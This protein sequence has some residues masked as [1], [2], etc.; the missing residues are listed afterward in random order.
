ML[1]WIT[2]LLEFFPFIIL[3]AQN[4][5]EYTAAYVLQVILQISLVVFIIVEFF[6]SK[7]ERFKWTYA[8]TDS[9]K[10]DR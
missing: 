3:F 6:R 10:R 1:W 8:D 2:G 5:P 9:H 4:F 7:K